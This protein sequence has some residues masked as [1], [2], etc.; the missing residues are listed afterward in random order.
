LPTPGEQHST[1]SAYSLL[2]I[3][4]IFIAALAISGILCRWIAMPPGFLGVAKGEQSQAQSDNRR[5]PG[6]LV[7]ANRP[8]PGLPG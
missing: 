2:F 1:D 6:L 3:V 5:D 4:A 8:D 7:R